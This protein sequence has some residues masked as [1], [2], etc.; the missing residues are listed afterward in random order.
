MLCVSVVLNSISELTPTNYLHLLFLHCDVN[1][2]TEVHWNVAVLSSTIKDGAIFTWTNFFRYNLYIMS[3][4]I[5]SCSHVDLSVGA[6]G[7]LVVRI[8][9]CLN[10]RQCFNKLI[11]ALF[12]VGLKY[13]LEKYVISSKNSKG[14]VKGN[15][16]DLVPHP[17]CFLCLVLFCAN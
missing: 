2:G 6:F 8:L 3:Y 16:Q 10:C 7:V 17:V 9:W 11:C 1:W 12:S 15:R 13:W 4:F 5:R 14:K